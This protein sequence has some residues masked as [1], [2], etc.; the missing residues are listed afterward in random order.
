MKCTAIV[1]SP[2]GGTE[3]AANALTSAWDHPL[4][5]VD[6]CN[7]HMD[8]SK[9]CFSPDDAVLIAVPSYAGRV[10]TIAAERLLQLDGNH[11]KAAIVCVYGN[12][13]YE[14]TLIELQDIAQQ[15]GFDVIAAVAAVA[16]HSIVREYAAGRPDEHDC[17]VL[18]G[19]SSKIWA[20]IRS[21]RPA[22]LT[23]PGNRPYKAAAK[24]SLIPQTGQGCTAC[25]LCAEQC[26]AAAID[27]ANPSH[28]DSERCI[29]CMRC[30][31]ICPQQAKQIPSERQIAIASMLE[32]ACSIQKEYELYL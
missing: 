17:A 32:K 27:A 29:A 9:V 10:P 23:V 22:E 31:A 15:A 16:E 3:K 30:V 14:D 5:T 7:A 28:I 20:L 12:R 11:A 21:G 4:E 18:Q 26:P 2:T 13:A 25:G 6:L 24:S 1:F 19:Y 8:F